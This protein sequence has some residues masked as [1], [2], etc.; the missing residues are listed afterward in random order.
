M[1]VNGLTS[2]TDAER[3]GCPSTSTSDD[4]QDQ[5]RAM[6]TDERRTTTRLDIIHGSAHTFVDDILGY[7]DIYATW[8]QNCLIEGHNCNRLDISSRLL[9]RYHNEGEIFLNL[10][11]TEDETRIKHYLTE[12]KHQSMQWKFPASPSQNSKHSHQS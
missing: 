6:T 11:I 9:E 4:K 10:I 5:A 2:V 12:S 7:H 8:V 1:F 3:S